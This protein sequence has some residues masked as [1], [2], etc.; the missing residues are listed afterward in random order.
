MFALLPL[1]EGTGRVNLKCNPEL[2]LELRAMYAAVR[3][4]YH[5][6]KRHWSTVEPDGSIDETSFATWSTAPTSSSSAGCRVGSGPTAGARVTRLRDIGERHL[7]VLRAP[8]SR[9]A[10]DRLPSAHTSPDPNM[11]AEDYR[12]APRWLRR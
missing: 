11:T 3:P 10:G 12:S 5:Q 9:E 4:G 1:D 7:R 6:N 8:A 2:A